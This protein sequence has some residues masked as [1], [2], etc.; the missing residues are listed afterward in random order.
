MTR[1]CLMK[2]QPKKILYSINSFCL[3]V[4]G[5]ISYICLKTH[6]K[7]F[8]Y[9]AI[10]AHPG[11][12]WNDSYLYNF[13]VE[14]QNIYSFCVVIQE[15][16]PSIWHRDTFNLSQ[17]EAELLLESFLFVVI[18]HVKPNASY[19]IFIYFQKPPNKKHLTQQNHNVI[20]L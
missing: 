16:F 9:T 18:C 4:C 13:C 2:T 8:L 3:I 20:V 5:S 6:L 7:Q 12:K 1:I 15:K 10:D 19:V 17:K 11:I 14:I